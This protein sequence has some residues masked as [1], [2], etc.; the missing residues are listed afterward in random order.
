MSKARFLNRG[1]INEPQDS[2]REAYST[3]RSGF[4]VR[5]L[6]V[7]KEKGSLADCGPEIPY[8][9]QK[10]RL[11]ERMADML[12]AKKLPFLAIFGTSPPRICVSCW[13]QS[14]VAWNRRSDGK[15]V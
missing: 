15:P 6:S 13:S 8:Q 10:S 11:I 5:A 4:R 12:Q 1:H 2:I 9:V 14:H 7:E 3:G